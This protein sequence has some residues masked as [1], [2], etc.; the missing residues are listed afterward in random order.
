MIVP[1][2]G[3][4]FH[5]PAE[6]V[7][8]LLSGDTELEIVRQPDNPHDPNACQVLLHG[9]CEGGRHQDLYDQFSTHEGVT[10]PLMLGYIGAKTG[11]AKLVAKA[12]DD[13]GHTSWLGE[14]TFLPDGKPAV[15]L[16]DSDGD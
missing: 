5:P 12:M 13:L 10:N 2:V 11:H 15:N 14:L 8:G 6:D 3:M 1:L 16:G 4:Y 9:F 7:V